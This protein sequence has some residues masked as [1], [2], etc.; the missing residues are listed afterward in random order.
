M[1]PEQFNPGDDDGGTPDHRLERPKGL[2][3]A[4][5]FRPLDQELQVGLDRSEIDL[6][7]IASWQIR[8]VVVVWHAIDR[9]RMGLMGA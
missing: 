9:A 4:K 2:L 1:S 8:R 5:S 3:L 7:R 6:F